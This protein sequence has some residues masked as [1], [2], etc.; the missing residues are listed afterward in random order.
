MKLYIDTTA[1]PAKALVEAIENNTT[2]EMQTLFYGDV[3]PLE[4]IFTD[5]AGGVATISPSAEI[6]FG[7]GQMIPRLNFTETLPMT[8]SN[9]SYFADLDL[10]KPGLGNA[11]IGLPSINLIYELQIKE[12][13]N[14]VITSSETLAQGECTIKNQLNLFLNVDLQPPQPPTGINVIF[15]PYP[16]KPINVIVEELTTPVAPSAL[17]A[18]DIT[19][20]LPTKPSIVETWEPSVYN[21]EVTGT[22]TDYIFSGDFSGSDPTIYLYQ[23]ETLRIVNNTGGHI[24]DIK[25][26]LGNVVATENNGVLEY[27]FIY[28]EDLM[29]IKI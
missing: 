10:D 27:R 5:G 18:T 24:I 25:D 16:N 26:P 4:I 19:D 1:D 21:A 29:K 12:E 22:G 11:L 2:K 15:S 8:Y 13:I 9:G 17:T 3:L 28:P 14:N 7:I 23:W 20:Q 6:V